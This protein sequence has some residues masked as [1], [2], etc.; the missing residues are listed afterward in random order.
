[1]QK[2]IWIAAAAF[3]L[4]LCGCAGR[5]SQAELDAAKQQAIYASD[6]AAWA[7]LND[8]ANQHDP[9]AARSLAEAYAAS[10]TP[11]AWSQAA[12]WF[13]RAAEWGDGL[14]AFRLAKLYA[15]G[16]GVKPSRAQSNHWLHVAAERQQADAACVLGLRAKD[17]GDVMAAKQW[18]EQ[19]AAHGSAEAMFQLGIAYQEGIGVPADAKRALDWYERSAK[20]EMPAALQTLAMAYQAGD[21]GLP[22]DEIK[23]SE[24]F[25]LAAHAIHDFESEVF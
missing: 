22:R 23:A 18:F 25:N 1:M 20:L 24:M 12:P 3:C 7:R 5:P 9:V 21:L 14:A 15:K 19:A 2:I 13:Q 6:G 10:G 4:A 8:W 11:Q 16:L 17:A